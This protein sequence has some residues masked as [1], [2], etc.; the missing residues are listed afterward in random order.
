LTEQH[1]PYDAHYERKN[2]YK[3]LA[4]RKER[5]IFIFLKEV[6]T[7]METVSRREIIIQ[8]TASIL[9]LALSLYAVFR[10][11]ASDKFRLF[12]A[13]VAIGLI[14]IR[15][16]RYGMKYRRLIKQQKG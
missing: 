14:G 8:L 2:L 6:R 10:I 7:I 13:I 9:G 5:F 11:N 16:V 4:G 1:P 3:P 12:M 15:C